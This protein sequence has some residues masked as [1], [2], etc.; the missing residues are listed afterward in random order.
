MKSIWNSFV[1]AFSMYSK[2]PMPR[3]E[4]KERDRRYVMLFFPLVGL[5]IAVLEWAW[6]LLC[7]HWNT[8]SALRAAIAVLIPVAVSGGIHV[9]GFLDVSDACSSWRE[10]EERLRILKD[11]HVGAFAVISAA[12]YFVLALGLA[13]EV[14]AASAPILFLIF[15]LSRVFSAIGVTLLPSISADG[16][17]AAFTGG[18]AR[19]V[20]LCLLFVFAAVIFV[21]MLLHAPLIAVF[22]L[23]G[24]VCAVL[25]TLYLVFRVFKGYSGDVAGHFL[26]VAELC[27]LAGA[28]AAEILF[29]GS[30]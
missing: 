1:I 25:Y 11:P 21:R 2:I 20:N 9:D 22:V 7:L 26:C 28:V 5:V 14:T 4:W 3:V 23:L 17:A 10:R 29:R 8:G 15:P 16:T 30:L 27:M 13:S 24:L 6:F 18:S 12:V 19:G